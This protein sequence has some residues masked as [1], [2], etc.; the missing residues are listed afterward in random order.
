MSV[1]IKLVTQFYILFISTFSSLCTIFPSTDCL[2]DNIRVNREH[3]FTIKK[4]TADRRDSLTSL[5]VFD[6][7]DA[8]DERQSSGEEATDI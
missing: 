4:K 5:D 1:R 7:I 6:F 8:E 2:V 3:W